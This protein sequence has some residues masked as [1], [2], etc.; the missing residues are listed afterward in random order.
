MKQC[1]VVAMCLV[2]G[3][4]SVHAQPA[5]SD[6]SQLGFFIGKWSEEG[7]SRATQTGAFGKISGE[8]TCAWFSGGPS[9]V[10]RETTQDQSGETDSIYILSYDQTRKNYSMSGTDNTGAVYTGTG[11][12]EQGV[13]KWTAEMRSKGV[14]TP[15]RYTFR[16]ASNG[17]RTMDVEIAAGKGAW[18]KIV[19]VTYKRTR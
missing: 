15:M 6:G 16:G 17:S 4:S 5:S 8:E 18:A 14:S 2:A 7:Q 3:L 1:V 10:C 13:W 12:L 11:T 19:A 9:V